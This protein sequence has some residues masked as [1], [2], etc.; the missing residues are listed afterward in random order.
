MSD[1]EFAAV[2]SERHTMAW[3]DREYYRGGASGVRLSFPKPTPLALA[4]I[5]VCMFIFIVQAI[6]APAAGLSPMVMWG[7]LTLADGAWIMQPWRWITY[8]YLHGSGGHVFFNSLFIYFFVPP[9]ERRWGAGRTF[10]FYTLGGIAAGVLYAVLS[11][12]L[13]VTYLIGAS[14]SIFAALGACAYLFPEMML[15]LI[16]PIRIAAALFALLFLLTIVGDRDRSDAA[17]LGGL[18]FGFF[19]PMLGGPFLGRVLGWWQIR[20]AHRLAQEEYQE[21]ETVDRILE[22]VH[23]HG[24]HSLTWR[25]RR[26]LKRATERQRKREME[27]ARRRML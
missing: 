24:M 10:V 23:E 17:H 13:P 26:L 7:S 12:F 2:S 8:Q 4:L 9:L 27:L 3:Q 15:F 16:I 18:A 11:L 25:E 19:A 14:G 6:T 1:S 21:Q 22:K 5:G 20:R